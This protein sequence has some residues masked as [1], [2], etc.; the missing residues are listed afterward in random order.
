MKVLLLVP[1]T[2]LARSYGRLRSFSNPQ[3]S[4]GIA[5]IASVLRENAYDVKVVDAYVNEYDIN[6]IMQIGP[7]YIPDVLTHERLMTLQRYAMHRFYL[8]PR[9]LFNQL[10][11][12]KPHQ[13]SKYWSGLRA[14]LLQK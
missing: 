5:Y 14:I 8:K 13:L 12:F 11:H 10:I 4:I 9:F 7:V 2:N 3:P 6:Q 1:P